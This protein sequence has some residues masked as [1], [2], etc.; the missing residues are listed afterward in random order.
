MIPRVQ[1]AHYVQGYTIHLRFSDGTEGDVDL[2]GEL[3][4]ELFEPL[5]DQ[6]LF[7]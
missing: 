6:T 4:G 5:K 7:R 3:Y 1:E 2:A